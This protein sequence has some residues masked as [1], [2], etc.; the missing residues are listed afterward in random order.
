MEDKTNGGTSNLLTPSLCPLP[1][2]KVSTVNIFLQ[3]GKKRNHWSI[4][5]N[6]AV[7]CFQFFRLC[8]HSVPGELVRLKPLTPH[9][10]LQP[11]PQPSGTAQV[12][13]SFG[14][15]LHVTSYATTYTTTFSYAT[16]DVARGL[17]FLMEMVSHGTHELNRSI[18]FHNTDIP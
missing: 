5:V 14:E 10:N 15:R 1:L 9:S 7:S 2:T 4:S 18:V 11:I 17:F 12:S 16:Y 13:R 6:R 8:L 3:A